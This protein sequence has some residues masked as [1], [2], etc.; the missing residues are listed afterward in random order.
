[1]KLQRRTARNHELLEGVTKMH[2]PCVRFYNI[3]SRRLG[4][5]KSKRIGVEKV[6]KSRNKVLERGG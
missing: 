2:K 4:G 3:R 1:M 6:G 5:R